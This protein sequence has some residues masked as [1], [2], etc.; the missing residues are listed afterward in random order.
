MRPVRAP[1]SSGSRGALRVQGLPVLVAIVVVGLLTGVGFYRWKRGEGDARVAAELAQAPTTPEERVELWLRLTGPQLH[2]R[3]GVVGR[4]TPEMPWLVTHALA[5]A[6]GGPP[7]LWGIE[8]AT[9]ARDLGRREGLTVVV[10][11][12]A[13]HPLGRATLVGERAQRV[14]LFAPAAAPDAR[15]RLADLALHLLEGIPRAL[16]RDIPGARLEIR[17]A[18]E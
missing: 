16:E 12:P 17:V 13:P 1:R 7:E 2:H 11:L 4:F 6:D 10:S 14:P 3:L 9:L 18:P 8:C 15:A 5:P